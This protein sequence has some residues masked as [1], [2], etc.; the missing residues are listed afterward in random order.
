M[1]RCLLL[2]EVGDSNGEPIV[3]WEMALHGIILGVADVEDEKDTRSP[4]LDCEQST[5]ACRFGPRD[6]VFPQESVGQ[7]YHVPGRI[8]SF[9]EQC[10]SLRDDHEDSKWA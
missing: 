8:A 1:V 4:F 6:I 3:L 9:C 2:A 7:R 10:A 5:V